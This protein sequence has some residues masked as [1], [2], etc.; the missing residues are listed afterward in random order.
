MK[1]L[2][3]VWILT[4]SMMLALSGVSINLQA[5]EAE[6]EEHGE[7]AHGE[8]EHSDHEKS[9]A[10][11]DH[12]GNENHSNKQQHSDHQGYK[13]EE[14]HG[15]ATEGAHEGHGGHDEHEAQ[16]ASVDAETLKALGGEIR[17]AGPGTV[18]QTV[19]LP[20][21]VCLN[22]ETVDRK[23]TRLNSSHVAS[24]YAVF[25]WKK[26]IRNQTESHIDGA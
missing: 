15:E 13:G 2:S 14:D 25:C 16:G 20:G 6:H 9:G 23:S 3:N 18:R 19:S 12:S 22:K 26:K 1:P 10:H 5:Q 24:S 17:I 8:Q 4:I 11:E 7:E 21:E